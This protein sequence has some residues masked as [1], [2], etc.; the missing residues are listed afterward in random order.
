MKPA[1]GWNGWTPLPHTKRK[2]CPDADKNKGRG[3]LNAASPN[4]FLWIF[5]LKIALEP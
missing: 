2:S 3:I 1:S 4:C 5:P